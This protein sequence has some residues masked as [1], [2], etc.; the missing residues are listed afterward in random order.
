MKDFDGRIALVTGGARGIGA[1]IAQAL[2][3]E[4]AWV[5]VTD[6]LEQAGETLVQGMVA[7]GANARFHPLD[8]RSEPGWQTLRDW[9]AATYGRLDVLVNAAGILVPGGIEDVSFAQYRKVMEISADGTFLS[10][11]Y[12]RELLKRRGTEGPHSAVV[13][14][15]SVAAFRGAPNGLSYA[16]SRAAIL[17]MTQSAALEWAQKGY[18]I[19][20]NSVHPGS[21][22]TELSNITY[23]QLIQKGMSLDQAVTHM[24][25]LHPLGRLGTTDDIAQAVLYLAS[26]RASWVT[27]TSLVV[28]GGRL[29]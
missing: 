23:E 14:I 19:R 18:R 13:N 25:G 11:K 29:A 12:C 3:R 10:F 4:G 5:V 22:R 16:A 26:E 17:S 2:A 7:S 9:L 28:D 15:S 27:G 1:G 20:V 21:V 8:V 24:T 6:V